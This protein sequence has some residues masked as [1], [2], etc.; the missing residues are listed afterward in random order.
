MKLIALYATPRYPE[1]FDV[2]YFNTHIPLIKN[3][4]GLQSVESS[5]LTKVIVGE[6]AP[7]M[8]TTMTFESKESMLAGLNSEEMKTAGENLDSF[9]KGIYTL[10]FGEEQ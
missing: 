2:A 5:K 9:A 8:I 10:S 3:V 1:S 6:K 4:P 7:Y